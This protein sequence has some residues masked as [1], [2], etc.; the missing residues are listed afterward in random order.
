MGG[1]PMAGEAGTNGGPQALSVIGVQRSENDLSIHVEA[2]RQSA[3]VIAAAFGLQVDDV[4]VA[5]LKPKKPKRPGA[6]KEYL[7]SAL[8]T[9]PN[10]PMKPGPSLVFEDREIAA[11]RKGRAL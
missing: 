6:R 3:K 4:L 11:G 5:A 9:D 2:L 1:I 7:D 10:K 8:F